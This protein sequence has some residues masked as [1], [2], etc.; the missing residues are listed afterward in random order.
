MMKPSGMHWGDDRK[1]RQWSLRLQTDGY[2]VAGCKD[3]TEMIIEEQKKIDK[4]SAC[5]PDG[6]AD[7]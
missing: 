1:E 6:L 2:T 4:V 5:V 7:C 3:F